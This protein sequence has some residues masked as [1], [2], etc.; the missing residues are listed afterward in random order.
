MLLCRRFT[1]RRVVPHRVVL[2]LRHYVGTRGNFTVDKLFRRKRTTRVLLSLVSQCFDVHEMR[3]LSVDYFRTIYAGDD[4]II[5]GSRF[6]RASRFLSL[7]DR[8]SFQFQ[9]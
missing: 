9:R 8:I 4:E 6:V 5:S 3:S 1:W 2:E 7:S